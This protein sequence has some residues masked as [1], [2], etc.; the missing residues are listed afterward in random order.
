MRD[1]IRA[2]PPS[3][4]IPAEKFGTQSPFDEIAA[5]HFLQNYFAH[6]DPP[7]RHAFFGE[8]RVSS[9]AGTNR[10]IRKFPGRCESTNSGEPIFASPTRLASR[11]TVNSSFS[12]SGMLGRNNPPC[13]ARTNA[14]SAAKVIFK[15]DACGGL[16][17]NCNRINFK[18]VLEFRMATGKLKTF[19]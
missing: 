4:A 9:R 14:G 18:S 8:R 6:H 13:A 2:A 15:M 1:T 10:P 12:G 7:P 19:S 11:A 17:C 3:P 16:A 5:Q